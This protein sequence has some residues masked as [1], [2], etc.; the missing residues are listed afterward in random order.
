MATVPDPDAHTRLDMFELGWF[1]QGPGFWRWIETAEAVP[2][3]RAC[4]AMRAPPE[5]GALALEP[6]DD[7]ELLGPDV[8]D[9]LAARIE[10]EF[11]ASDLA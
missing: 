6:F 9:E 11:G 3:I 10:R 8:L 5:P 2:Y 7:D 4:A 1:G